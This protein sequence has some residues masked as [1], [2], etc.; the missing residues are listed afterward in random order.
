MCWMAVRHS[1][2]ITVTRIQRKHYG[3]S[4][5][6]F[7]IAGAVPK[8]TPSRFTTK[9]MSARLPETCIAGAARLLWS[10]ATCAL[11]STNVCIRVWVN[12]KSGVQT[13]YQGLS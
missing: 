7:H 5:L 10:R 6:L 9:A 1:P 3:V 2:C 12:S 13:F 8:S 4:S 11:A